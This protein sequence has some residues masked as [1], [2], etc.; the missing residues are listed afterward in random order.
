MR[1]LYTV[2][3]SFLFFSFGYSQNVKIKDPILLQAL[4]DQGVDKNGDQTIQV[5]E[6]IAIDSLNLS[7]KDIEFAKGID[8]FKNLLRTQRIRP[9]RFFT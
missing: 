6:A 7:N 3:L 1:L 4:I 9:I 5:E 2:L 8:A